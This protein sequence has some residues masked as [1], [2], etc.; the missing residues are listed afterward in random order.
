LNRPAAAAAAAAACR[1]MQ[2]RAGSEEKF[3]ERGSD[4]A[5]RQG[6]CGWGAN[7]YGRGGKGGV[8]QGEGGMVL[9]SKLNRRAQNEARYRYI[10]IHTY[11]LKYMICVCA[12][13]MMQ[14]NVSDSA[15]EK[16]RGLQ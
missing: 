15:F 13:L 2:L 8:A 5:Q 7:D 16:M 6:C 4:S 3:S 11:I 1:V 10:Y 14:V 9:P 12:R